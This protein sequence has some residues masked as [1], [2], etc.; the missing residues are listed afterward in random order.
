MVAR[1]LLS[2]VVLAALLVA[3]SGDDGPGE[4]GE[5]LRTPD[6]AEQEILERVEALE[7]AVADDDLAADL[8]GLEERL[9]ELEEQLAGLDDRLR[10][11][12]EGLDAEA[13]ARETTVAEL[14][15]LVI[16]LREAVQGLEGSV[17]AVRGD[18]DSLRS[19]HNQLRSDHNLLDQRFRDHQGHP[20]G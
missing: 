14:R 18:L 7:A 9:A 10:S 17:G 1:I 8:R 12:D 6:V 13:T 19:D 4:A 16:E 15:G 11:V 5:D 2:L 3:C 20:P